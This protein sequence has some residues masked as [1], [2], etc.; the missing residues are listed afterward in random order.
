MESEQNATQEWQHFTLHLLERYEWL[1]EQYDGIL[2]R[3]EHYL[4][5]IPNPEDVPVFI[6]NLIQAVSLTA[7][8]EFGLSNF[9]RL[10]TGSIHA[11]MEIDR[12]LKDREHLNFI[13]SLC[14]TSN[15][16]TDIIAVY[17]EFLEWV[18][19]RGNIRKLKTL[20]EY[21]A[22]VFDYVSTQT[23]RESRRGYLCLYKRRELLRIG[24]RDLLGYGSIQELCQELTDLAEAS[25]LLAYEDCLKDLEAYYGVPQS[26]TDPQAAPESRFCVISMG[27]FGGRELNF[28]SDI[29]L[30]FIYHDEGET[31]GVES[32]TGK[33]IRQVS[34]Q[35]FYGKLAFAIANYLG[36]LSNEGLIYRVDTRLRPEGNA[37]QIARSF[38]SYSAFF[39]TQALAWEKV[40]YVKARCVAGDPELAVRFHS[41]VQAF[42]FNNNERDVLLPEV[43]R[44]KRRI[45]FE[46]LSEEGRRLDIKRG[47]GGIREIEFI[48]ACYQLLLGNKM[49]E[50]RIRASMEGLQLLG[51]K[52]ILTR[53]QVELLEESYWFFRRV[54][55][56]IQMV[57]EAQTHELPESP[58]E[59]K[60][61]AVRLGFPTQESFTERLDDLRRRV[62]QEFDLFFGIEDSTREEL[63]LQ[64]V[65]E[66]REAPDEQAFAHL[67]KYRMDTKEGVRALRELALGTKDMAISARGQKAFG[68][69]L[70][71]LMNELSFAANP[72]NAIHHL[73]HLLRSH[74]AISSFYELIIAHPSIM[75]L[76]IRSLGYSPFLARTLAA[77]PDWLDEVL[78]GDVLASN[79]S[80]PPFV[81][82][83]NGEERIEELRLYRTKESVFLAIRESTGIETSHHAAQM[84][85]ELADHCIMELVR[86]FIPEELR[87]KVGVFGMGSMGGALVHPFGD[88][89]LA[90]VCEDC[91]PYSSERQ[92]LEQGA[93]KILKTLDA[94]SPNGQLW[95]ADCRLRPDGISSPLMTDLSRMRDYYA[96]SAGLWEFQSAT[97][98]R[99]ILGTQEIV[100]EV[101]SAVW[102]AYQTRR[103]A[104]DVRKE[105][106]TMRKRIEAEVKIPKNSLYDLKR[107][108]GGLIDVE[109]LSQFFQLT[110]PD[111]G[112]IVTPRTKSALE[113]AIDR[114][115]L[116]SRD[117]EKVLEHYYAL[118]LF[119]RAIR[120]HFETSKDFVPED[121]DAQSALAIAMSTQRENTQTMIRTFPDRMAQMRDIFVKYLG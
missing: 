20:D 43:A 75:R 112:S 18:M 40:A 55:H 70:P 118:R 119:Q 23:E 58:R 57:D 42:V 13:T 115:A 22:E 89:D 64:D 41:L 21:T 26:E 2:Q 9:D 116:N 83:K 113:R 102:T 11:G 28:S 32:S 71:I 90:F 73:N 45:D 110:A 34:N 7:D 46:R 47:R 95:K 61:L 100:Q 39:Y 72:I 80:V 79:R 68:D 48:V 88:I 91:S 38:A 114:N 50:F 37:G 15:L 94:H 60:A 49:P 53:E 108:P 56:Q 99:P 117:G 10:I 54:E 82:R 19:K 12:C 31:T 105:I 6:Q 44:L 33:R 96:K 69:L 120:F 78:E 109:F 51:E 27:K 1:P 81:S 29:D 4:K 66:N 111:V 65:I 59:L 24:I 103:S 35:E 17:P 77:H 97:K 87:S 107:S 63:S 101:H 106:S 3:V 67:K 30:N 25:C 16:F 14:A 92:A 8:P 85:T 93:R 98:I 36:D 76:L 74:R 121:P 52:G 86:L 62:R 84:T 5:Y 104:F